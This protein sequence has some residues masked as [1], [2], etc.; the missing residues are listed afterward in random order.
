M[1]VLIDLIDEAFATKTLDEWG[2]LF[3]AAGLIWGPASTIDELA[4]DPQAAATGLFPT[5]QHP[6]GDF[7]TV[8]APIRIRG[9]DIHPRGPAPD[10]GAHTV[11]VLGTSAQRRRG[12]RAGRRRHRR[13]A[14]L[15]AEPG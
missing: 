7:R 15:A 9:A 4:A 3:D 2:R 8:G 13:T 11:E 5:I 12:R 1:P 10:L 14:S 6:E